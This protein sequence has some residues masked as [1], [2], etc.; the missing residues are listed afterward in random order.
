MFPKNQVTPGYLDVCREQGFVAYRG[1]EAT[2][3][4][5]PRPRSGEQLSC[6]GLRLLD[7]YVNVTPVQSYPCPTAPA[8]SGLVN[9]RASR[10]LRRYAPWSRAG[11]RLRLRRIAADLEHAA[12]RG[13]A[14]HIWWHP[15]DFGSYPTESLAMLSAILDVYEVQRQRHGMRSASMADIA[16]SVLAHPGYQ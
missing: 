12:R 15:H 13:A 1:A 5:R 7:A 11:E 8:A 9:V 4:Q 14:Y 10:Y 3:L 2:P 16:A 6:R